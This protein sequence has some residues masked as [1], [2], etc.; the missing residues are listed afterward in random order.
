M[1]LNNI[2]CS[3]LWKRMLGCHCR[4]SRFEE[5]LLYVSNH[6]EEPWCH[7]QHAV[8]SSCIKTINKV[9]QMNAVWNM[10]SSTVCPEICC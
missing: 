1:E 3:I 5:F 10:N 6:H 8:G 2:L 4:L 9:F 7:T